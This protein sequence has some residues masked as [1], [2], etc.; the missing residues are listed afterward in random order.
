[1]TNAYLREA[2]SL[3]TLENLMNEIFTRR[4]DRVPPIP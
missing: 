1:M 3:A 2:E 4:A